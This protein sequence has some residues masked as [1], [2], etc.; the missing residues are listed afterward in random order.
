MY[1]ANKFFKSLTKYRKAK[2]YQS[3]IRYK[4]LKLWDYT[5]YPSKMKCLKIYNK[6]FWIKTLRT[7]SKTLETRFIVC[8]PFKMM[9]IISK[10]LNKPNQ[11][12]LFK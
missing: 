12:S 4:S 9:R 6:K 2:I 10:I 1:P 8:I 7:R 3:S 5:I 11:N